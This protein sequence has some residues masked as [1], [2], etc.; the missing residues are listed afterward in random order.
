MNLEMQGGGNCPVQYEGFIDGSQ[1][2]FRSRGNGWDMT[3][4]SPEQDIFDVRENPP[5]EAS[6][7]LF[8]WGYYG[9]PDDMFAAGWMDQEEAQ[10]LVRTIAQKFSD[11]GL[12]GV[13]HWNPDPVMDGLRIACMDRDTELRFTQGIAHLPRETW[14]LT[15]QEFLKP[16]L[17]GYLAKQ[18]PEV[19][20][21]IEAQKQFYLDRVNAEFQRMSTFRTENENS[22]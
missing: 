14:P 22:S 15:V 2:Y 21:K 8:V 17:P 11:D 18:P 13:H 10:A 5:D 9:E 16:H 6:S 12:R 4:C 7:Y 3:I 20:E 19:V 1:F